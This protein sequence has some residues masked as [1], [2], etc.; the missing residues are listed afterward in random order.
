M[1]KWFDNLSATAKAAY[2]RAHPKSKLRG[3]KLKK[4]D[5]KS[6]HMRKIKLSQQ[7]H[8]RADASEVKRRRAVRLSHKRSG[9]GY[10]KEVTI[11]KVAKGYRS[12]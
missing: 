4:L 7:R 8:L 10:G 11:P 5:T 1:A 9:L 6:K 3:K 2:L 12:L